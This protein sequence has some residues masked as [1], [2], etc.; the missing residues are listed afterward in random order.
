MYQ[1]HFIEL[2]ERIDW[3]QFYI[4][5]SDLNIEDLISSDTVSAPKSKT[6]VESFTFVICR[7][8]MII[9]PLI[10][11]ERGQAKRKCLLC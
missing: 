2:S 9:S 6:S 7:I 3:S 5:C 11:L 8:D 4:F 10:R 1:H